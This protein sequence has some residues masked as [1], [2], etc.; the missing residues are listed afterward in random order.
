[1]KRRFLMLLLLPSPILAIP[2]TAFAQAQADPDEVRAL[3]L[4][5]RGVKERDAGRCDDTP[6]GDA[7]ACRKALDSFRSAYT[8]SPK[9]L[10]ALRNLAYVE[11]ALGM[12][13]SAARDFR[14]LARKAPTDPRAERRMWATF[15]TKEAEALEALV[16]HIA[17]QVRAASSEVVVTL[18]G[19]RLPD[20]SWSSPLAV[21]PGEHEV[22]A[23]RTGNA[24]FAATVAI[25]NGQERTVIV[26]WS[27][28][29]SAALPPGPSAAVPARAPTPETPA[30]SASAEPR[31]FPI[32]PVV[33]G[34]AGVAVSGIGLALGLAA[35]AKRGECDET[36]KLCPPG[37]IGSAR[38]LATASTVVTT[39]GVAGV[40]AGI[41]WFVLRP[42]TAPR[43]DARMW[44]V[45]SIDGAEAKAT[46]G[47]SF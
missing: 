4:F 42:Q 11:K 44:I 41:V 47:G 46:L 7:A 27:V 32:G 36:S 31:A 14:E 35:K 21:D 2:H 1:M 8:L 34:G 18:D 9:A 24:P 6:L 37:T 15:A 16:P 29:A 25:A 30:E 23:A 45:P 3:E 13:A 39:I 28:S 12:T 5:G 20:A 33:V 38:G 19:V 17:V 10:G 22:K 26:E 40:V 43:H